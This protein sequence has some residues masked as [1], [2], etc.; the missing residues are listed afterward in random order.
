MFITHK[1]IKTREL[2]T[3]AI[4]DVWPLGTRSP[5]LVVGPQE[6]GGSLIPSPGI[7]LIFFPLSLPQPL[8]THIYC[9]FTPPNSENFVLGVSGVKEGST[10]SSRVYFRVEDI[11]HNGSSLCSQILLIVNLIL[12]LSSGF[13][14]SLSLH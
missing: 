14:P 3:F 8:E 9:P 5:G 1:V 4:Q 11:S 13:L 7:S 2:E 6:T 12:D 10:Y